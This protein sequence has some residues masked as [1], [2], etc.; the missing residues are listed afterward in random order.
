MSP[1]LDLSIVKASPTQWLA[2]YSF[3]D[4]L[5]FFMFKKSFPFPKYKGG[6][7]WKLGFSFSTCIS[8]IHLELISYVYL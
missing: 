6:F 8:L 3:N 7:I 2:F 1:L 5:V 4:G